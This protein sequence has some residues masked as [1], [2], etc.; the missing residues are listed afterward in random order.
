VKQM[1][2]GSYCLTAVALVGIAL[3]A[4]TPAL[5]IEFFPIVS[6]ESSTGGDDLYPASNLILGPGVGFDA[7]APYEKLLGGADGNWVTA[8][9][10][11][12]PSDYIE[13]A[14]M[15]VFS[16]DLGQDTNLREIS[17]WGYSDT[18]SNGTSELSLLFAT[19]AEGP[20]GVGSSITYN[21]TFFPEVT[22]IPRQSFLFSE[23]VN[24]RY[25]QLT[26]VDN[27]FVA[28]GDGTGGPPGLAGGDRVGLGEIAF[29][30]VPEPSTIAL[31]G[32]AL[33][34]L[35]GCGWRKN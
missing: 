27:Y 5:A 14:G 30:N 22:G 19:D 10:G 17:I 21:P 11:G 7:N 13:V 18:N 24:A 20:D 31:V 9:P 32:L 4:V 1:R 34:C 3:Y 28:P 15:P 12:F 26:N 35:I 33:A 16:L 2:I 23:A 8:A 29:A 6:I 25:V